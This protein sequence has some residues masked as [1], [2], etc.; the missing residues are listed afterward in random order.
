M[1]KTPAY[2]REVQR[3]SQKWLTLLGFVVPVFVI[4]SLLF[5]IRTDPEAMDESGA[6]VGV[7]VAGV[8]S[9]LPLALTRLM[10]L[11]T[12][13]RTDG[14]YLR[15]SPLHWR[16]LA[17]KVGNIASVGAGTYNAARDFGGWGVRFGKGVKAYTVQGNK[18]IWLTLND[19]RAVL[20]GSQRAQELAATIRDT[21]GVP[22]RKGASKSLA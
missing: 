7:A 9:L 20:V 8:A 15:F 3:F 2:Y 11:V 14:V 17:F 22:D 21:L 5:V 6:W 13:V 4:T 12:E 10:R 16:F 18:C 1:D 19:G